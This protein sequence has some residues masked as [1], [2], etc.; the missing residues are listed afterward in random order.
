MRRNSIKQQFR[1]APEE[2]ECMRLPPACSCLLTTRMVPSRTVLSPQSQG[3]VSF[4]PSFFGSLLLLAFSVG[5]DLYFH[6][7]MASL[8]SGRMSLQRVQL[9]LQ[10]AAFLEVVCIQ[11]KMESVSQWCTF[12]LKIA[13]D[14]VNGVVTT[15]F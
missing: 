10:P 12:I 2:N 3:F 11:K 9:H 4:L 7:S 6:S 14:G 13:D 15:S 8:L 5:L 1:I